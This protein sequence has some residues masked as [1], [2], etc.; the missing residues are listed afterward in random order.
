MPS[1]ESASAIG[2]RFAL[3]LRRLWIGIRLAILSFSL[4]AAALVADARAQGP[5]PTVQ[6][7]VPRIVGRWS[8]KT[9]EDGTLTLIIY[10]APGREL[11]YEFSGGQK[12]HAEG[13]FTLRGANELSFTPKRAKE[14][15]KWT[16]SFDELGRLHLKIEKEKPKDEEEYILKRA[17]Q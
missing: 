16:Y 4:G 12:E 15:V 3:P 14:P 10:P 5:Y 2:R 13:T 6:T 8:G 1:I 7:S 17:G 11:S 9:E